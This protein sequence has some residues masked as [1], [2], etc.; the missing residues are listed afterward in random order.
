[1]ENCKLFYVGYT[2]VRPIVRCMSG[3]VIMDFAD[4]FKKILETIRKEKVMVGIHESSN[5][6][7]LIG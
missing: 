6:E 3:I 1:M 4:W 7:V 2:R 5:H